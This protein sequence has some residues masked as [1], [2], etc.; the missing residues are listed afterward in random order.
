[1]KPNFDNSKPIPEPILTTVKNIFG[2]KNPEGDTILLLE[3]AK[4]GYNI[5][6]VFIDDY[7]KVA[8]ENEKNLKYMVDQRDQEIAVL[9]RH[10]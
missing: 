5:A 7:I 9:K 6:Q 1:M 10:L 4:V 3:G 8:E 2:N